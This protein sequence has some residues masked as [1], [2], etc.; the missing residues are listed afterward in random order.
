[1]EAIWLPATAGAQKCYCWHRPDRHTRAEARGRSSEDFCPR[2]SRAPWQE[3]GPSAMFRPNRAIAVRGEDPGKRNLAPIRLAARAHDRRARCRRLLSNW[4]DESFLFG[5]FLPAEEGKS[6][7]HP[8][9][10]MIRDADGS[11]S[12][13][14]LGTVVSR[15]E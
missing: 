2:Q 5:E 14:I 10:A 15:R 9:K 8:A 4:D 12:P 3:G 13:S 7:K 1:M 6:P 11:H